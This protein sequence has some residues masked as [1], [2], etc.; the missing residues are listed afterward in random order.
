M[1][2]MRPTV[3]KLSVREKVSW[4]PV[5]RVANLASKLGQSSLILSKDVT[6]GMPWFLF[7]QNKKKQN[8]TLL[9]RT[10]LLSSYHVGA[11]NPTF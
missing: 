6:S 4:V 3:K 10:N 7:G 11:N 9:F 2:L 8:P 1:H 5:P